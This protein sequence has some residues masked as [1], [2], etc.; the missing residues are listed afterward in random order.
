MNAAPGS[1]RRAQLGILAGLFFDRLFASELLAVEEQSREK[2]FVALGILAGGS[3]LVAYY[4]LLWRYLFLPDDSRAWLDQSIFTSLAM[5]AV[6]LVAVLVWDSL[7]VDRVDLANLGALPVRPT[8]LVA[9]KLV[10]LVAF[11]GACAAS[12]ALPSAVLFAGILSR[13]HGEDLTWGVRAVVGHAV[14][15]TAAGLVVF[16]ACAVLQGLLML[17]LGAERCRRVGLLLRTAL[18]VGVLLLVAQ[19]GPVHRALADARLGDPASVLTYPPMWF[20]GLEA[21][22]CGTDA[23]ELQRGAIV[24]GGSLALLL[25]AAPALVLAGVRGV[26]PHGE[27]PAARRGPRAHPGWLG[28][29]LHRLA[30]APAQERGLYDFCGACMGRSCGIASFW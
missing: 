30:P 12:M 3:S 1:G 15:V 28:R 25:L 29:L 5:G 17:G 23:P 27:P 7:F 8:T 11:G 22:I 2:L 26:T 19:V 18:V 9:A 6:A 13:F 20:V 16:L 10:G 4:L 14:A 21:T 24:A